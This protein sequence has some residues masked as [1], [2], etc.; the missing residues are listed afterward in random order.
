VH[1]AHIQR[2]A[3][4]DRSSVFANCEHA[5]ILP[6]SIC[7]RERLRGSLSHGG[8]P[9]QTMASS[10]FTFSHTS[11]VMLILP[12]LGDGC[13]GV[14]MLTRSPSLLICLICIVPV[15]ISFQEMST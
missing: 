11:V 15:H 1:R 14:E 8:S 12:S 13:G 10:Y 4:L 9:R 2:A 6:D 7:S 3:F 5:V